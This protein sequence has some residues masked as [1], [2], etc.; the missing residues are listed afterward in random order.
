MQ[1]DSSSIVR[2]W[3][4]ARSKHPFLAEGLSVEDIAKVWDNSAEMYQDGA[5]SNLHNNISEFLISKNYININ[6]SLLDIGSGP[7][8]YSFRFSNVVKNIVAIDK[9]ERML[10]RLNSSCKDQ[11]TSNICTKCVDWDIFKPDK[12]YDIAFSSLCPPVNS[13]DSILKMEKCSSDLCIYISSM[14]KNRDSIYFE[15]WNELGKEYTYEGYD[16]QFPFRFL[17]SIGR[18]PILKKFDEKI[19]K[20]SESE[21]LIGFYKKKFC[22]YR[23]ESEISKV[24]E[25][26]V[27]SHT[28]DGKVFAEQNNC[29]G[30]LIWHP[31][32]CL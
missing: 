21:D 32:E 30:L 4:F 7:G 14:S 2:E 24:I 23:E 31:L 12:K 11:N 16:T 27:H 20:V 10:K 6:K 5:L 1:S 18:E 15:I 29:L 26:I 13:S 3:D 19:S 25:D 28:E 8:T 22:L 17:K 9:S